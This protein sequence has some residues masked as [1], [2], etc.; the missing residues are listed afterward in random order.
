VDGKEHIQYIGQLRKPEYTGTNDSALDNI[1]ISTTSSAPAREL[2]PVKV[3]TSHTRRSVNG[4]Q[5]GRSIGI[6]PA[7]DQPIQTAVTP[8]AVVLIPPSAAP[9]SEF[10][11]SSRVQ[12]HVFCATKFDQSS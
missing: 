11:Q 9:A 3:N 8:P 6:E 12:N 2:S 7:P 1:V 10:R 5:I 4:Q